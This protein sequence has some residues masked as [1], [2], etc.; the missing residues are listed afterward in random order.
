MWTVNSNIGRFIEKFSLYPILST[1]QPYITM[2]FLDFDKKYEL[3]EE[4][5]SIS[6]SSYFLS[7]GL[8]MYKKEIKL[9]PHLIEIKDNEIKNSVIEH[10]NLEFVRMIKELGIKNREK[11]INETKNFDIEKSKN[12]KDI[13]KLN[14]A[15]SYI[16][17]S[18]RIGSAQYVITSDNTNEY[19]ISNPTFNY[20]KFFVN[21]EFKDDEILLGRKNEA[22]QS[23]V[24][25]I[26]NEKSIENVG[27]IDGKKFVKLNYSFTI[28]GFNPEKQYIMINKK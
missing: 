6:N 24:V 10:L 14:M 11:N 1:E 17:M 21:K 7:N 19:L 12:W 4:D 2:S 26:L 3:F 13:F 16:A 22:D 15:S 27:E 23:G 28:N 8:D 25:L 20:L 18:G 5:I 9:E